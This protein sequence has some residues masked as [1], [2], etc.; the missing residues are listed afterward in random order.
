MPRFL[1]TIIVLNYC[2]LGHAQEAMDTLKV[3][4]T[5][6]AP[7]IIEEHQDLQGI[8]V[9]LWTKVAEDLGLPFELRR[10]EFPKMLKKT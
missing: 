7:F 2:F 1:L 10:M 3:G 9:W 6:A 8:N 5:N 4:Y